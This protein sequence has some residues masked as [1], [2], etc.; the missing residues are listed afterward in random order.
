MDKEKKDHRKR[1]WEAC[2]EGARRAARRL[3]A[4]GFLQVPDREQGW[5]L[6]YLKTV[7]VAE[8]IDAEQRQSR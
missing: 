2:S 1:R 5:G 3:E 7:K 8:I 4:E 6:G